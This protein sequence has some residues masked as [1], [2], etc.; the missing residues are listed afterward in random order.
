MY[1]TALYIGRF[2][3]PHAGHMALLPRALDSAPQAIVG[4]GSAWQVRAPKN[5]ITWAD[6][7]A[8]LPA[9]LSAN[10][11]TSPQGLEERD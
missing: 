4:K 11:H 8:L 7:E 5:P 1:D 6:R 9:A 2:E 3:P 10:D